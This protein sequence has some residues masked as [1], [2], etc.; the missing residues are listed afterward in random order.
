VIQLRRARLSDAAAIGAVHVAAWRS[1]YPGLLPEAYLAGMSAA[2]QAR[3][4]ESAIASGAV[5]L[6]AAPESGGPRLVGFTTAGMG[7]RRPL[8]RDLTGGQFLTPPR[9]M[10]DSPQPV[11]HLGDGEIETLYV[12]DDWRDQ[13]VG[14]R[15][16]RAAAKELAGKGCR[17]VYLWVLRDNPSRFFYQ[18]LGGQMVAVGD[19]SVAGVSLAQ[20]AFSWDPID[21]L[22]TAEPAG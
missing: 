8:P 3:Y 6:V 5:V 14:R 20:T 22:L 15:L 17:S 11:D 10:L 2:R 9:K 7:R 21:R 18:H 16:I 12:L 13:G 19:T 1:A 4:Y